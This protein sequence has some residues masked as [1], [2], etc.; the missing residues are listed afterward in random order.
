MS[1]QRPTEDLVLLGLKIDPTEIESR[2][3]EA[4]HADEPLKVAE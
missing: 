2:L 4:E 3:N 1:E